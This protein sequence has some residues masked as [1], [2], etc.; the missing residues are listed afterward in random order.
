M[1]DKRKLSPGELW[2]AIQDMAMADKAKEVRN[3]N[4]E[5]LDK[6]LAS[7]GIDPQMLR[8]RAA[9]IAAKVAQARRS[10][11]S[12]PKTPPPQAAL[13][14]SLRPHAELQPAQPEAEPPQPARPEAVPT[15]ATPAEPASN[16]VKMRVSLRTRWAA[17][18]VAATMTL[19]MAALFLLPGI[20]VVGGGRHDPQQANAAELRR[21]AFEACDAKRWKE[22]ADH[23]DEAR[24]LDPEGERLPEVQNKRRQ[25]E[26]A[27]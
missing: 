4:A 7:K 12:V 21:K 2:D 10:Q 25:L 5:E 19:L 22:C 13:S 27:R 20:A 24:T 26:Q 16:V 18:L 9:A 11:A 17:T 14:E 1:S 3:M 8:E 6:E 15:S 23:L